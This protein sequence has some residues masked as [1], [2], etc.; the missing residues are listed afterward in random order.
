MN[1][2]EAM[3][4]AADE[5]LPAMAVLQALPQPLIVC[6]GERR[7]VFVNYAA[8]AFFGASLSVLHASGWTIFWP[9]APRSSNWPRP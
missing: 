5:T 3:A 7:I 2:S 6:D 9:S 4:A 8:E 1:A